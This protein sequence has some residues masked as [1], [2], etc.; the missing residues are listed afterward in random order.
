MTIRKVK[1][2]DVICDDPTPSTI[3]P[4]MA[5]TFRKCDTQILDV[6]NFAKEFKEIPMDDADYSLTKKFREA[7][8]SLGRFLN[9]SKLVSKP[10]LS[11]ETGPALLLPLDNSLS[12][13]WLT[14]DDP[15]YQD[16]IFDL[17]NTLTKG[18]KNDE[19]KDCARTLLIDYSYNVPF[20]SCIRH[21]GFLRMSPEKW[22]DDLCQ[23]F[24]RRLE[25]V[26]LRAFKNAEQ[27]ID[28]LIPSVNATKSPGFY[29]LWPDGTPASRADFFYVP[30]TCSSR[31]YPS[32]LCRYDFSPLKFEWLNCGRVL[33][34]LD[35][36][37]ENVKNYT[38]SSTLLRAF[39]L[40]A[41]STHTEAYRT[42]N[43]DKMLNDYP[44]DWR[45]CSKHFYKKDRDFS[46]EVEG[47]A[48]ATGKIDDKKWTEEFCKRDKNR[49]F[50]ALKKRPMFPGPNTSFSL[51]YI[52]LFR[53]LLHALEKGRTGFPSA[54][55]NVLQSYDEFFKACEGDEVVVVA[56]DRR[57]CEQWITDNWEVITKI[58]PPFLGDI[59]NML[60]VIIVPSLLGPRVVINGLPSGSANT[61][62]QNLVQGAFE[63]IL[64]QATICGSPAKTFEA[65]MTALFGDGFTEPLGFYESNGY[66][67][68]VNLG[69]DDQVFLVSKI[70]CKSGLKENLKQL[71]EDY[72]IGRSLSI[73]VVDKTTV[74]GME[75]T[76]HGVSV[77]NS[78]GL[79]KLFLM[80]RTMNGDAA[81]L[82]MYAR[83][84]NLPTYYDTLQS[85]FTKH[86]F[87]SISSYAIGAANCKKN[88]MKFGFPVEALYNEYSPVESL[89]M[90]SALRKLKIDPINGIKRYNTLKIREIYD[91]FQD[92]FKRIVKNY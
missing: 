62:F 86:G 77:S 38:D 21:D 10:M 51:S 87:G 75:I 65:A 74:F 33:K 82:K 29:C 32:N 68:K 46:Y 83:F 59:I 12:K 26:F 52:F 63:S 79:G 48:F 43:G 67:I 16:F 14:Y 53:T 30:E 71:C 23:L 36:S 60:S 24:A 34:N 84:L 18:A 55:T 20:A 72:A 56:F 61:T 40:G 8:K 41:C 78:L 5:R 90:G 39:E 15:D 69:T 42:N 66:R 9:M 47:G 76:N 4:S 85:L 50:G 31:D 73:D 80:E 37:L 45:R 64:L 22:P 7:S 81:A 89:V 6:K 35:F 27:N 54:N 44:G 17:T 25:V 58:I 91:H 1:I 19:E 57:T 28:Q 3:F 11:Q 92:Y 13:A 49:V 88:Q 2:G 70:G